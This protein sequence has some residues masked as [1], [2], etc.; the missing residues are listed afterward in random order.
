M[1]S[2]II[3][4]VIVAL[5]AAVLFVTVSGDY[6]NPSETDINT[7]YWLSEGPF[8]TSPERSRFALTYSLIENRDLKFSLPLAKFAT[9]DLGYKNGEYVSLFAPGV[10]I[11]SIPGYLIGKELN[12]SQLGV[13]LTISLFAI[14]NTLLIAELARKMGSNELSAK[15]SSL[16]F[17]FA[18]PAFAYATILY[19]HH[20]SVFL[21]LLSLYSLFKFGESLNLASVMFIFAVG[22]TVDYPNALLMAPIVIYSITRLLKRRIIDQ[23]VLQIQF[24]CIKLFAVVTVLPP[25]LLFLLFNKVSYGS[26]YQLSGTV[27]RVVEIANDKPIFYDIEEN[28]QI[29]ED[30]LDNLREKTAVSFFETRRIINGLSVHMFSPD[31]GII[32]YAP[33]TILGLF[34]MFILG[35][36]KNISVFWAILGVNVILY[37]MWGDPWGGWAFG[38][39][40]LIPSYAILSIFIPFALEKIKKNGLALILVL[41]LITYSV[42]VNALGATTLVAN[43]PKIEAQSLSAA[44]GKDEPYTFQRNIDLLLVNESKSFVYNRFLNNGIFV[45]EYYYVLTILIVVGFILSISY[46][47]LFMKDN[48]ST[49]FR[50]K[51][52]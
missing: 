21:I 26:P 45:W 28:I 32:F 38:S 49:N 48:H 30:E 11:I 52:K 29:E 40:Y 1:K 34:G 3:N 37:S 46:L 9:P 15:I 23:K 2:R 35:R 33:V 13:F 6:G 4:I 20:I 5:V 24:N 39:R 27:S 16:L 12:M 7:N 17:L 25:L 19:Q 10:S 41:T 43:P 50:G 42:A 31:R 18:T 51:R 8:E 22:I 44:S 47:T 14:L 36:K